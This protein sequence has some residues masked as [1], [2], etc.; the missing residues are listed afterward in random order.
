M[1]LCVW[2]ENYIEIGS[3]LLLVPIKLHW[4]LRISDFLLLLLLAAAAVVSH[5]PGYSCACAILQKEGIAKYTILDLHK[6][7]FRKELY[8]D[9]IGWIL[10]IDYRYKGAI[11]I[12]VSMWNKGRVDA[13]CARLW[14]DSNTPPMPVLCASLFHKE[15]NKK[16][17]SQSNVRGPL[18]RQHIVSIRG[19]PITNVHR[20]QKNFEEMCAQFSAP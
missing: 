6:V 11:L 2:N 18:C 3:V 13:V 14:H 9:L 15:M 7:K 20:V 19:I 10:S 8:Q 17:F 1:E 12:F 5:S 16:V 4:K